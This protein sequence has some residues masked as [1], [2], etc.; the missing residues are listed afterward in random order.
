MRKLTEFIDLKEVIR[1]LQAC[2]DEPKP[3]EALF[4]FA[5]WL[6]C[7]EKPIIAGSKYDASIW[8]QM[9]G[10]FCDD[11]GLEE[12]RDNFT[13]YFVDFNPDNDTPTFFE[14]TKKIVTRII[15][16]MDSPVP[17]TD[18]IE[19]ESY[20]ADFTVEGV[21]YYFDA[22]LDID[23]WS[24]SFTAYGKD[25]SQDGKTGITGTGNEFTVFATIIEIIEKFINHYNPR[26]FWFSA[27]E[28][29]RIKLYNVFAQKIVN[30]WDYEVDIDQGL[31]SISYGFSQK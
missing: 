3:S 19:S 8:A 17:F 23:S 22:N 2:F 12:P 6:T 4:I 29:S 21:K 11:Q 15:E 24:I 14:S 10:K 5:A 13:D 31:K 27:K 28:K 18:K 1:K 30:K 25:D 16:I 7:L 9:V 20:T 26:E